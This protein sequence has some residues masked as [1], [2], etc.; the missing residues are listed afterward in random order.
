MR[1]LVQWGLVGAAA[2][3]IL[4]TV[5]GGRYTAIALWGPYDLP[6]GPDVYAALYDPDLNIR[7]AAVRALAAKTGPQ[8]KEAASALEAAA[9][10]SDG[11]SG[12][13]AAVALLKV[14]SDIDTR[15]R[16]LTERLGDADPNV[17][18]QAAHGLAEL[19]PV[20]APA[21]PALIAAVKKVYTRDLEKARQDNLARHEA[22][23]ALKE[24]GPGAIDPVCAALQVSLAKPALAAEQRTAPDSDL[25]AAQKAERNSHEDEVDE[26]QWHR[27][28]LYGVLEAAG[29]SAKGAQLLLIEAVRAERDERNVKAATD[30]LAAIGADSDRSVPPLVEV[31]E[32]TQPEKEEIVAGLIAALDD[33]DPVVRRGA[34]YKLKAIGPPAKAAVPKLESL[35]V[36]ESEVSEELAAQDALA[37]IDPD[38]ALRL[39]HPRI[40]MPWH[41]YL[42]AIWGALL[43]FG[44]AGW[45][46]LRSYPDEPA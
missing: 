11:R 23:R 30:A 7:C 38:A 19:G 27:R 12:R 29:G 39:Y 6:L 35:A 3:G 22:V 16:I 41:R 40:E 37:R 31:L 32:R 28:Q 33:A 43:V 21:A 1:R 34:L 4:V 36:G 18:R 13:L 17:R 2:V 9:L 15:L 5:V 24:I 26:A 14:G 25:T 42:V 44:L 46:V 20:A 45:W 10:D 8:A